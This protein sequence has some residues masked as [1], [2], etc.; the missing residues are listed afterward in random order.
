MLWSFHRIGVR[1]DVLGA[2][3]LLF[4]GWTMWANLRLSYKIGIG[5]FSII[6]MAL[7]LGGLA[8]QRM[9]TVAVE[10]H[11]LAN[12]SVP[13]V[14]VANEI[15]RQS[16]LTMYNMRAYGLTGEEKY[17]TA[18][19]EHLKFINAAIET[20][21][22]LA[23]KE[24]IESL[25]AAAKRSQESVDAY[26][27][28][29]AET[30]QSDKQLDDV[31][32]KLSELAS[33][34]TKSAEEL[35]NRQDKKLREELAGGI[36]AEKA[37]ERLQ[38]IKFMTE[39]LELAT[40]CRVANF[41][42]Q[43]SRDPSILTAV[44]PNFEK[45]DGLLD[46]AKKITYLEADQ[47]E[48]E[49]C[50]NA[51]RGY[52]KALDEQTEVS[53]RL[54]DISKRRGAAGD[55]LLEESKKTSMEMIEQALAI[56]TEAEKSLN[57]A[58][59]VV[60]GGL[61][62]VL[63]AGVVL[64]LVIGRG[65]TGPVTELMARIALIQ[66]TQDLTQRITARGNDEIGQ[67]AKAFNEFVITLH[68][69]IGQV[70]GSAQ[71]VASA[72]TE[73]AASAEE[74]SS[75]MGQQSQQVAQISSAIEEM[76][77]SVV[78][79]AR[80]S[81]DV[82][83]TARGSG[84]AVSERAQKVLDLGK[85]TEEI[86]RIV[87]V[88]NDIADQTNLLALNAAIEAARAGEH[89]RGFAVVADEVR[90][91]ADRTTKATEEIASSIRGIQSETNEAGASLQQVVGSTQEVATMVQS[92][93]AAAEQ[94]SAASEQVSKNIELISSVAKQS[95]EGATQSAAAATQLS[96]KAEQ[97]QSLVKKFT[98]NESGKNMSR[99][100]ARSAA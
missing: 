69:V 75:G 15:E 31:R 19:R 78:E 7:A 77:A 12:R 89:G 62:S 1:V 82:A 37:V 66:K 51:A 10:S 98:I 65:I 34:F 3:A 9:R 35:V 48:I 5:F 88:I 16:L 49:E 83:T 18:G 21:K 80:K 87:D 23:Q 72:A 68:D 85:K 84:Q 46:E 57:T 96:S 14:K 81:G 90:K 52:R 54:A 99:T 2:F 47:R 94:Q 29:V 93:A 25:V 100:P 50:R 28:I 20:A 60:I 43:L 55:K 73:I 44:M 45:I 40:A 32:T 24:N 41:R 67:L 86:G 30:V 22:N 42:S 92:I 27:A 95:S 26:T 17:L 58:S 4:G 8:V 71:E 38:K 33:V 76:S 59:T 61:I 63:V 11:E 79:V 53:L 74:M 56:S 39:V 70:S 13:T 64:A 91:L 36:T 97:L 6:A